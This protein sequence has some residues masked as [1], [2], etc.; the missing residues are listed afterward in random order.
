MVFDGSVA[1][2]IKLPCSAEP[3]VYLDNFWNGTWGIWDILIYGGLVSGMGVSSWKK[4]YETTE[5]FLTKS[6]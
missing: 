1:L 3:L 5:F 2:C 4:K 6:S